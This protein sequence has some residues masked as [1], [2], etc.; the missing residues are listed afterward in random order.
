MAYDKLLQSQFQK[1][2]ISLQEVESRSGNPR[3]S[4][5]VDHVVLLA[6]FQVIFWLEIEI[7]DRCG[8]SGDLE[9]RVVV[10]PDR[11]RRMGHIRNA[12]KELVD[13]TIQSI[14]VFLRLL[15]RSPEP[16]SSLL[17]FLALL[18]WNLANLSADLIGLSIP[19]LYLSH[20]GPTLHFQRDDPID[21]GLGPAMKAI[22][23]D[24]FGVL[25][26]IFSVEHRM[27]VR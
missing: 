8:S 9:V 22:E 20:F 23:F 4:L 24:R 15:L 19:F 5:E 16:P 7:G 17:V 14:V 25:Y 12:R 11:G 6:E 27:T 10:V 2:R 26:H 3:P 13:L 1:D 21:I 18:G